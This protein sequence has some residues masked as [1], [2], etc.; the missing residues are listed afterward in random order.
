MG[1]HLLIGAAMIALTTAIHAGFMA[2]GV[3]MVGRW[4]QRHPQPG[5]IAST[6]IIAAFVLVMIGAAVVEVV[7][8]AG[9]FLADG[10][11]DA[12]EP[13][14][15]FTTVTYTTLGYGDIV[16]QAPQRQLAS[17]CAANGIVMFGWTT[18]LLFAVVQRVYF[19]RH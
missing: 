9:V 15:Y 10:A 13:A 1:S 7:C 14:V 6:V 4:H 16:L 19:P 2:F 11:F 5:H 18:A 3:Q 12:V 17:I 8:W